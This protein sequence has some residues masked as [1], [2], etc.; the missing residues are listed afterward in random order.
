MKLSYS[1]SFT[2]N[3]S[4]YRRRNPKVIEGFKRRN[5]K[6]KNTTL[7]YRAGSVFCVQP[8]EKS[9]KQL[10]NHLEKVEDS[11]INNLQLESL[12]SEFVCESYGVWKMR[13][14][15]SIF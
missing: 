11:I 8:P 2:K 15:E 12:N 7:D 13:K 1:I 4:I 6:D 10:P 14:L 9:I 5:P 3:T